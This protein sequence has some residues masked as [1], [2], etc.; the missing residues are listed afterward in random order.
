MLL[1]EFLIHLQYQTF[2]FKVLCI[3]LKFSKCCLYETVDIQYIFREFLK[4]SVCYRYAWL[5][6]RIDYTL[7]WIKPF[8]CNDPLLN[9]NCLVAF[10]QCSCNFAENMNV[11]IYKVKRVYIKM[12]N[13]LRLVSVLIEILNSQNYFCRD[14]YVVF[15]LLNVVVLSNL[16]TQH[17]KKETIMQKIE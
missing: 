13:F 6:L 3:C 4:T 1:N 2:M 14:F 11:P 9:I 10:V 12:Y 7:L 15:T 5:I 16:L 8:K 17:F